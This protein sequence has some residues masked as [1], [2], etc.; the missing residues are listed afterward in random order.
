MRSWE[1][2]ARSARFFGLWVLD[3]AANVEELSVF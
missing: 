3:V 1:L 2:E